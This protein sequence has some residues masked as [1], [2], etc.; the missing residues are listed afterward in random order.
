M[1]KTRPTHTQNSPP[2][3]ALYDPEYDLHRLAQDGGEAD[4]LSLEWMLD[5][6]RAAPGRLQGGAL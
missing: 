4:G 3:P 6:Y 2:R 1:T 5:R